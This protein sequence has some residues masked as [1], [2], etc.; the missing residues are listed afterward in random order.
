MFLFLGARS[1][2]I[3]RYVFST[4]GSE[5]T[6]GS[7]IIGSNIGELMSESYIDASAILTQ[8][9]IQPEGDL[10]TIIENYWN[11]A[12]ASVFPN[13]FAGSL[14]V[15]LKLAICDDL[16]VRVTN[17]LGQTVY[18][19]IKKNISGNECNMELSFDSYKSGLYFI[20]VESVK[21]GY[22]K[23]FKVSKY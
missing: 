18:P 15:E 7:L 21:N 23:T 11:D 13:P 20:K 22:R 10:F 1:Q 17:I 3:E 8:G 16:E 2:S 9:F 12:T 14:F 6:D 4:S 5:G 19:L